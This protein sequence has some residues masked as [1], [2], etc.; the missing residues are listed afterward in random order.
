MATSPLAAYKLEKPPSKFTGAVA[1]AAYVALARL[2]LYVVAGP[3]YGYFRDEL[4]YLACGEHP[5]WGY[6]DQPPLI[7]WIAWFLQHTIGT[8]L[9][10]LRL[11]PALAHAGTIL[12]TG[13]LVRELGGKRWATFLA[14]TA[15]LLAP[16]LLA[17]SHIFSMNAFDLPLWTLLA[18]LIVRIAKTGNEKLWIAVGAVLGITILNK[19]AIAFFAAGLLLGV[20]ATPMRRSLARPWFWAGVVLAALIA[21]P[22]YLWQRHWDYPFLQ[23]MRNIR[24]NGR[25]VVLSP[26]AYL[27]DQTKMIGWA[28]T[29]LVLLGLVFLLKHTE[30]KFAILAWGFLFT[31]VAVMLLHGKGYYLMP[32]YPMVFAAG[33]VFFE[34]LTDKGRWA[35]VRPLY[36]A[37]ILAIGAIAMPMGFPILPIATFIQYTK[38][39]GIE[40]PKFEHQPE[41]A[42]PQFYADMYG[43]ED[44]AQIVAR[45]FNTLPPDERAKT[46]IGAPNYGEAGA[47]DFFGPK[48]GLP[49]AISTHQTYWI[50][51]PRQYTGESIILMGERNP[52]KYRSQCS[53]LTLVGTPSHPYARPD[54]RHA[55][56]H[57]RGLNVNLQEVW[58]RMKHWD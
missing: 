58:P 16:V 18:W 37:C 40:Q 48:Y 54:E 50:W 4:Y 24:M 36:A 5:S 20:I 42:L 21:L 28:S 19:Y 13:L 38:K 8:S 49:K 32:L 12:L 43:W 57:C 15:V 35:A 46:A 14:T 27:A 47:I 23:L 44:Q 55:I 33:A 22:N 17:L 30:R 51:G 10:A 45:Y 9:Y 52:D 31:V 6:V 7:A 29:L 34:Q 3:N 2:G 26:L 41:S 11:L 39:M 25:D 53:S 56:Y 1:I